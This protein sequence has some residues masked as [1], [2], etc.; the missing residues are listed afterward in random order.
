MLTIKKDQITLIWPVLY[1][2]FL[3]KF[4]LKISFVFSLYFFFLMP[5]FCS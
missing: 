3:S 2:W 5:V 1:F 4:I